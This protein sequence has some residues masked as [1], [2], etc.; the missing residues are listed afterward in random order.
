MLYGLLGLT[1][2]L[3]TSGSHSYPEVIAILR[4]GSYF[5]EAWVCHFHAGILDNFEVDTENFADA[6]ENPAESTCEPEKEM[7][8]YTENEIQIEM[9]ELEA[10]VA[11][12]ENI[13]GISEA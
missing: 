6:K 5:F 9:S 3:T 12:N 2:F 11:S 10:K 8:S 4:L 7:E 13:E 1:S